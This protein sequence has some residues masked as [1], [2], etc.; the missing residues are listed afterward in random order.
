MASVPDV[1][2]ATT[3]TASNIATEKITNDAAE[4]T[5][6]K[7]ADEEPAADSSSEVPKPT[8]GA[9]L[10]PTGVRACEDVRFKKFFKMVQ[11]GVPAGA[12]KIKMQAEGVQP[13]ILE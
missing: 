1:T 4:K 11:F 3:I 5:E 10:E 6:N 9:I 13:S 2:D 7:P 12:V 8:E